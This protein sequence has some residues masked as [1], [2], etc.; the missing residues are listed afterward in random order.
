MQKSIDPLS[1]A[2][3]LADYLTL[4]NVPFR[5]AHKIVGKIVL[6]CIENQIFLTSLTE[7]MLIKYNKNFAGISDKWSNVNLFLKRRDFNGGTGINSVKTQI[8][9]AKKYLNIK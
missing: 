1:F 6:D 3:E 4:K 7:K 9:L 2:T 8:T 5:E